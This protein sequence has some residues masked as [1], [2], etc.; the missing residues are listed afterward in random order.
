ML[1]K[2]A[3]GATGYLEPFYYYDPS[4]RTEFDYRQYRSIVKG[5]L[6]EPVSRLQ[7]YFEPVHYEPHHRWNAYGDYVGHWGEPGIPT[8]T[9]SAQGYGSIDYTFLDYYAASVRRLR[10]R[11][12]EVVILPPAFACSWYE[13]ISDRIDAVRVEL[14][15]RDIDFQLPP[16]DFV[17]PDS[18]FFD[19]CYHL[20]YAGVLDHTHRVLSYLRPLVD[21]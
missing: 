20:Q 7:L 14:S 11:G 10:D 8:G 15:S 4:M 6:T 9:P 21:P 16:A 12:V 18:L 1:G 19:S 2:I 13:L 3:Y 5:W 17:Y